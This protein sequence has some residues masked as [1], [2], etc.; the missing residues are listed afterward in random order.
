VR[1]TI[2]TAALIWVLVSG[3]CRAGADGLVGY[4]RFDTAAGSVADL[5]GHG[6]P[7]QVSHART[8][9]ED[10]TTVLALDGQQEIRIPASPELDLQCGFS[11]VAKVKI[12][13]ASEGRA[14]VFKA[15]Q[16]QLR[17]DPRPEMGQ[18]SFLPYA[19]SKWEPRVSS[20]PPIPGGWYHLVATWDGRQMFLWVNDTPFSMPRGGQPSASDDLPLLIASASAP[21]GGMRGAIDYVKIYRKAL[22]P[23]EVMME[24]YGVETAPGA[25]TATSFDFAAGAGLDGWSPQRGATATIAQR[26]LV[27]GTKNPNSLV[28]HRHLRANI[29]KKDFISLR[30][31][32]DK[33]NQAKLIFVTT[34]GAGHIA[35]PTFADQKPHTYLLEPWAQV[36][37]GGNLLALGLVPS[38][39]EGSTAR[40]EHLRVIETLPSPDIQVSRIFTESTLP[41][42]ERPDRIIAR[43]RNAGAPAQNLTATLSVPEGVVLKTPAGQGIPALEHLDE[44]EVGWNVEAVRPVSGPFRVTVGNGVRAEPTATAETLAFRANR[45]LERAPYVP[46]PVPAKTRYT[47]WTHYCPLWK[48]GTTQGWK[49]IESWPERQPVLGWYNEGTPEVADWHIKYMLEHGISGVIYCWYRSNLNGPVEHVMGHA[50]HDGLLKARYLPMIKFGILWANNDGTGVG[51]A[52]DMVQNLLPYWIDNYFSNPSYLRVAGKPVLY[53]IWPWKLSKEL[54]GSEGT[55]QTFSC[56]RAE[57]KRRGLGGLYIVGCIDRK[58]QAALGK[59]AQEG[60]DASSAYDTVRLRPAKLTPVG[61]FVSAPLDEFIDQQEATWKFKRRLHLLPDITSAMM[62]WDSRP[63]RE[64]PFFWSG[65]TP[66]KFREL[67]RRAKA[68]MDSSPGS[69]PEKNAAVFCCWDEFGEGHY[70]EPTRGYGFSYLDVIRD[71]FCE[72]PHAH[73]DIAPQDVGR[74]SVDSWHRATQPLHAQSQEALHRTAWSGARLAAWAD[75]TGGL[76]N[77]EVRDGILRAT[78]TNGDPSFTLP[79]RKLRASQFTSVVVEMR[80]SRLAGGA[81]LFWATPTTPTPTEATSVVLPTVA[82]GQWHSYRFPVGQNPHWGGC[83]TSLRFDP[84]TKE[85]V[86]VEIKSIRLE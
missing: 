20:P 68:V 9:V 7:A 50:I 12:S 45:H 19:D 71:V 2:G 32:L 15:N 17:V 51:S 33:G 80:I 27:V 16:Y 64:D 22:L 14:I 58:D 72:G 3:P 54:G 66:E 23:R 52:G 81:Q 13:A 4:W 5:S 36:G 11:I 43:L 1:N 41:R 8:V 65:N 84:A 24:A 44:T 83:V 21:G 28:I 57:C 26:R 35:F 40:I 78:S 59:M 46:V 10:G 18:L 31:S 25:S 56:M 6:H 69:G 47:L 67:C 79:L 70:I 39:I 77:V 49:P 86:T 82:D 73:V 29:D 48:Q 30:M 74:A 42:A 37:W 62:G 76:K 34:K 53:V 55:R 63:W 60:W 61:D 38:D 75:G 85:H